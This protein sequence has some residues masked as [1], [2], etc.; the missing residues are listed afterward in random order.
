MLSH[1]LS[2]YLQPSITESRLM[3]Q[4]SATM[5]GSLGEMLSLEVNLAFV[6]QMQGVVNVT[7]GLSEALYDV[8]RY[9]L[10]QTIMAEL[11]HPGS[12]TLYVF[13]SS[14]SCNY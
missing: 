6:D 5:L 13:S 8:T 11:S 12:T 3:C 10:S 9:T 7:F 2:S 1:D 4:L 14:T